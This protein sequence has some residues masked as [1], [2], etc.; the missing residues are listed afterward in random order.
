MTISES[1]WPSV[2]QTVG[3]EAESNVIGMHFSEIETEA[4]NVLEL[5]TVLRSNTHHADRV[6]AQDT[7][8]ELTIALEHLY[9]HTAELLPRLQG[10]LEIEP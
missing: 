9:H 7:A 8:A 10:L 4:E 6:E 2:A 3:F 1:I 5:L